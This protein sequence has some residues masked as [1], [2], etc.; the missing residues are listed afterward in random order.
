MAPQVPVDF[1]A[2]T[3]YL[4]IITYFTGHLSVKQVLLS[5]VNESYYFTIK[6]TGALVAS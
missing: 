2:K 6:F 4:T 3:L 5:V 1:T